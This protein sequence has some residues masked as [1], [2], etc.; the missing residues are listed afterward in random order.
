M[1]GQI[2]FHGTVLLVCQWFS[3]KPIFSQEDADR[4]TQA[5][6]MKGEQVLDDSTGTLLNPI[7]RKKEHPWFD[8][9]NLRPGRN[10]KDAL[11]LDFACT[12]P[13][14]GEF[15]LVVN[16]NG[17][18]LRFPIKP[19]VIRQRQGTIIC[20]Y[21][22]ISDTSPIGA[23][24]EVYVAYTD[25]EPVSAS[26]YRSSSRPVTAQ[27]PL[28]FKVSKS[29]TRGEVPALTYARQIRARE[30]SIFDARRKKY[31]PPPAPPE[32]SILVPQGTALV[33][34]TPVLA[35]FEGDWLPAEV[36][37]SH[38]PGQFVVHWPEFG[39][40]SNRMLTV[41]HIA[42]ADSVLQQLKREPDRFSP[43]V[44]LAYGSLTPPPRSYVLVPK[45]VTLVPG[46]PIKVSTSS[47]TWDYTVSREDRTQVFVLHDS[48]L[49]HETAYRRDQLMIHEDVLAQLSKPDAKAAFATRL[50]KMKAAYRVS[51]A[52]TYKIDI[53]L[54]DGYQRVDSETPLQVG[55]SCMVSW[56]RNWDTVEIKAVHDDGTV[57]IDWPKWRNVYTVTRDSLIVSAQTPM[58]TGEPASIPATV[59]TEDSAVVSFRISLE[60]TGKKR[61]PV[62]KLIMELTG[63]DLPLAKEVTDNAPIDLKGGLTESAAASWKKRF[64]EAGAVTKVREVSRQ[65]LIPTR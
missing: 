25:A 48:H 12:G 57:D 31:G 11:E 40:T 46:T 65:P 27:N 9:T 26:R 19:E 24:V 2:L 15:H 54:P 34:G 17:K 23:D 62:M 14:T 53:D 64:E 33:P 22:D 59:G 37:A 3:C 32:S 5:E 39:H 41:S 61:V 42:I 20:A 35:A 4:A 8:L 60:S 16:T 55:Q 38:T 45:S 58:P 30:A 7:C 44:L 10:L 49:T 18:R 36:L 56:A 43:S 28:Y 29:V 47:T 50:D 21:S 1:R 63:L 6:L 13:F 51:R 52:R